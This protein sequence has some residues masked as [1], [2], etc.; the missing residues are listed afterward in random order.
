MVEIINLKKEIYPI[1]E[2]LSFNYLIIH[3]LMITNSKQ[4]NNF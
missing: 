3:F 2:S 4:I 1:V